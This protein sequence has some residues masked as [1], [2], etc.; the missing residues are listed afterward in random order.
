MTTLSIL[1]FAV[2]GCE[3]IAPYVTNLQNPDKEFPRAMIV[4]TVMVAVTAVLG[5]FAMGL[6]FDPNNVPKDLMMNGAYY[7]Q[8]GSLLWGR[9]CFRHPLC[10][11]PVLW[12]GGNSR[13]FH[14]RAHQ[15]PP[16]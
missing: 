8:I 15:V 2:G 10:D 3:R 4:M 1:V 7:C 5:T 16:E 11:L 14:R 9:P 6:M 12:P 13:H